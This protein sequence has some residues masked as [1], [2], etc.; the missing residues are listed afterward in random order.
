[1]V[2]MPSIAPAARPEVLVEALEQLERL[3]RE[4]TRLAPRDEHY[5][6]NRQALQDAIRELRKMIARNVD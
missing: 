4:M 5:E 1:M 3:Q 6:S 2:P